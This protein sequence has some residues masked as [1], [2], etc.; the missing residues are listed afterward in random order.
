[1]RTKLTPE[2]KAARALEKKL[3]RKAAKEAERRQKYLEQK[4][5][6]E[7]ER[8]ARNQLFL[9]SMSVEDRAD[10]EAAMEFPT[11]KEDPVNPSLKLIT[12]TFLHDLQQRYKTWGSLSEKQRD[13]AIKKIRN[14]REFAAWPTVNVGDTITEALEVL[15]IEEISNNTFGDKAYKLRLKAEYG[16][17]FIL[18]TSSMQHVE[19][20][21]RL[22]ENGDPVMVKA[23]VKWLAPDGAIAVLSARGMKFVCLV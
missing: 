5:K 15:S 22:K 8:E 13:A 2:E 21:A 7:A 14:A 17:I 9:S 3:E 1:M 19:G 4:K 18:Y 20:A 10:F 16:R 11:T 12:D 6:W 23:K